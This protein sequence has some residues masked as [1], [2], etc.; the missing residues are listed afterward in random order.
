MTSFN[1]LYKNNLNNLIDIK[2]N[3]TLVIRNNNILEIEKYNFLNYFSTQRLCDFQNINT[4]LNQSFFQQLNQ[5]Q[6]L[7]TDTV[8]DEIVFDEN[9]NNI[10]IYLENC[11]Y[12]L[13][14]FI[15][16]NK[17]NII[18]LELNNNFKSELE[19]FK[20]LKYEE[21]EKKELNEHFYYFNYNIYKNNNNNTKT[22]EIKNSDETKG[23]NP[24]YTRIY[25]YIII[26]LF[27]I[28]EFISRINFYN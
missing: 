1:N 8:Q 4:L 14:L 2:I 10:I 23:N 28:L 9:K 6:I 12:G 3:D 25:N 27:N 13:E 17:N 15:K 22:D 16:S 26:K 11:I 5:F 19:K 7:F 21:F 20:K 24:F 18:L